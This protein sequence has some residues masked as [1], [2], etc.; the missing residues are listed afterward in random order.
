GSRING[1]QRMRTMLKNAHPPASGGPREHPGL[2]VTDACPHFLRTIPSLSRDDKNPDD[3]DTEAEDH[4]G[5]EVRYEVYTNVG[6]FAK[7]KVVGR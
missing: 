6:R 7:K 3:V 5:D 2:F 1:W 4:V